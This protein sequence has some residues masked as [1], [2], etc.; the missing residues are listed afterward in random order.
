MVWYGVVWRVVWCG[1]AWCMVPF[2]MHGMRLDLFESACHKV[3][4]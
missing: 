1:V 3:L 2:G 4:T